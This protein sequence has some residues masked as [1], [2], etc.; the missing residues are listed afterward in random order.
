MADVLYIVSALVGNNII[1]VIASESER[2]HLKIGDKVLLAS[3]A[4]NPVIKK[5]N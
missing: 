2:K 3:K 4:F 1:K 5:I